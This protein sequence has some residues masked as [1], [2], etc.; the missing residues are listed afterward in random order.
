M[1]EFGSLS[2]NGQT[3]CAEENWYNE[4]NHANGENLENPLNSEDGENGVDRYK[5]LGEQTK[6]LYCHS[7][8]I[9]VTVLSERIGN[10]TCWKH[11]RNFS[12]CSLQ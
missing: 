5:N 8:R 9:M 3:E 1:M 6:R 12:K 7:L 2:T 11:D 10:L 4:E